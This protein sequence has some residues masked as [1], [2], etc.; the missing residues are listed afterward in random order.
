MRERT[1]FLAGTILSIG[2][3]LRSQSII[4]TPIILE[5]M[6]WD[7]DRNLPVEG[8]YRLKGLLWDEFF[9]SGA[10]KTINEDELADIFYY[11][12]W[13]AYESY[14]SDNPMKW[15]IMDYK[16]GYLD[17]LSLTTSFWRD[18]SK[19]FTA[20]DVL[21][22]F[23]FCDR[24]EDVYD[25]LLDGSG[26]PKTFVDAFGFQGKPSDGMPP[27]F[28]ASQERL[29]HFLRYME[30]GFGRLYKTAFIIKNQ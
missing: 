12:F 23:Y 4:A 9:L 5:A 18:C 3:S 17:I 11:A 6:R 20:T 1:T 24:E 8:T 2:N 26:D 29:I 15:F 27:P 19:P 21:C 13:D 22:R 10:H 25:I 14:D 30:Q 16:L 7:N 28:T